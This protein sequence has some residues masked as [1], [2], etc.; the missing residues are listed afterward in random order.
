M[1]EQPVRDGVEDPP[2]QGDGNFLV[3]GDQLDLVLGL[4]GRPLLDLCE[5][6][7]HAAEG[8]GQHQDDQNQ[9]LQPDVP[10]VCNEFEPDLL[11]AVDLVD[12]GSLAGSLEGFHLTG[13]TGIGSVEHGLHVAHRQRPP[14]DVGEEDWQ[15]GVPA[16]E[17]IPD[18]DL[19]GVVDGHTN[20]HVKVDVQ[21][22]DSDPHGNEGYHQEEHLVDDRHDIGP[23]TLKVHESLEGGQPWNSKRRLRFE[24][25]FLLQ[26]FTVEGNWPESKQNLEGS[27]SPSRPLLQG[28]PKVIGSFAGS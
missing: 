4:R 6:D 21:G 7:P 8:N 27:L 26:V 19:S 16:P 3:A 18:D 25:N 15:H 10:Q 14:G 28:L 24:G 1:D 12:G 9:K 17:E 5:S 13:D 22:E 20:G 23:V 11:E 2:H